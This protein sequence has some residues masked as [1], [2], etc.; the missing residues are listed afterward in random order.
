MKAILMS[1]KPKYVAKILNG[2]KTI[3]I[4]KKFPKDYVGWVYIYCTK[5]KKHPVAPFHFKEGW[6]YKEYNDNTYYCH[7]RYSLQLL[8]KFQFCSCVDRYYHPH[9]LSGPFR[10]I[11]PKLR[12][13]SGL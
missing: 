12:S 1:I 13:S 5:D 8:P 6:F 4:R 7:F 3:E 2:E 11:A 9:V 10:A